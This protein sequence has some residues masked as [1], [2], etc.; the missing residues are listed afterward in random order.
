MNTG[1]ILV[2]AFWALAGSLASGM[3]QF[4]AL[5]RWVYDGFGDSRGAE[6]GSLA[7]S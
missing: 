4:D 6:F 7:I 5:T 1:V 2:F 3:A